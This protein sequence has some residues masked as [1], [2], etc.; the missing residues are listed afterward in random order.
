MKVKDINQSR[1]IKLKFDDLIMLIS[2]V[3]L[4]TPAKNDVSKLIHF[5][6]VAKRVKFRKFALKMEVKDINDLAT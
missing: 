5:G 1:A 2:L 4:Q 6:A 3:D